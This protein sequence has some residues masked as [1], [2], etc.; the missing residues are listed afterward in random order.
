MNKLL[1]TQPGACRRTLGPTRA[2]FQGPTTLPQPEG[3]EVRDYGRWPV[4]CSD[5]YLN[6]T[7]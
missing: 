3:Q 5:Q 7:R 4:I 1:H 6:R 2:A